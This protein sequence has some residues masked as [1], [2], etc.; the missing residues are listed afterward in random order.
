MKGES[1]IEI[2]YTLIGLIFTILGLLFS[3]ILWFL[4]FLLMPL[5]ILLVLAA[6]ALRYAYSTPMTKP[7]VERLFA[8][9]QEKGFGG[10][11]RLLYLISVE[12]FRVIFRFIGLSILHA[13][14]NLWWKPKW[15]PWTRARE[16]PEKREKKTK[17]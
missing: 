2:I 8:R 12:P 11:K 1:A 17:K 5:L 14:V 15:S 16:N 13:W 6:F 7:Y 9:L 10:A 4:S 3:I